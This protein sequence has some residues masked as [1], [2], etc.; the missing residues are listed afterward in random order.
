MHPLRLGTLVF[1]TSA[2]CVSTDPL[3]PDGGPIGGN[4]AGWAPAGGDAADG[5][6]AGFPSGGAPGAGG[7]GSLV[8]CGDGVCE[9]GEVCEI[10][11]EDCACDSVCGDGTCAPDEDCASCEGDCGPCAVCGD[12]SC[13]P[14][15]A[16]ED[17]PEDC[18]ACPC[19]ADGF[20]TNNGSGSATDVDLATDYCDL[21][22]CATDFDW[23]E[24][25]VSGTTT[26]TITFAQLQGDLDLEIYS[27]LTGDYVTGSYST[28]DDEQVTLSGQPSGRYWA[29]IYG[30]NG[31]QNF[32]Y[33]FRVE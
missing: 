2:A 26:A 30:K 33:C 17:C 4:D 22:V 18:G 21:S 12:A 20:E 10:C 5:G 25:S 19:A 28:N 15:E 11:P 3:Q 6:Y 14:S 31:A 27:A 7:Q 29:R 32:Y 9:P 8:V 13:D 1:V 23:L 16:C 24:F